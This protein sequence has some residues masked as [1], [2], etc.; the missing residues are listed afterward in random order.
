VA[1]IEGGAGAAQFLDKAKTV[2]ELYRLI[3]SS[4]RYL[5]LISPYVKPGKMR[6]LGRAISNALKR[7]VEV[8]LIVRARD[9]STRKWD[10]ADEAEIA[11]LTGE[12][13]KLQYVPDLHAKLYFSES[14]AL[15]TSL[16]LLESSFNNSI[17]I[18]MLVKAGSPEYGQL[19]DWCRKELKNV[20]DRLPAKSAPRA[21]A[22][23]SDAASEPKTPRRLKRVGGQE[24]ARPRTEDRGFCIECDCS[25]AFDAEKPFC[26]EHFDAWEADSADDE[27]TQSYCHR[28][29]K[30]DDSSYAEPLCKPCW[31]AS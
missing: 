14:E 13:M 9:A 12:K 4:K 24:E 27:E 19:K 21:R 23:A 3:D 30:P 17:E 20:L 10:E 16:N 5:W 2:H 22:P 11:R 28:C 25:I 31:K 1:P 15:V 18:G 7:G 26:R 6:D 29:G 8:S